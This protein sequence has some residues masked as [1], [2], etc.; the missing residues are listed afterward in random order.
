[1]SDTSVWAVGIRADRSAGEL[2]SGTADTAAVFPFRVP[3]S[4][5]RVGT[6]DSL[7]AL[8]DDL[9]KMDLLAEATVTKAYKQLSELNPNDEPSISGGAHIYP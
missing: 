6:L 5:L 3:A 7:M 1:M 4:S 9:G 8:S 2:K